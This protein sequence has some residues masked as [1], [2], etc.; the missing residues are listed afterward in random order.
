MQ[1]GVAPG[2]EAATVAAPVDA[3][4]AAGAPAGPGPQAQTGPAVVPD[5]GAPA[6]GGLG[7]IAG[8][9][10]ETAP[11]Q[12]GDG[13]AAS[14]GAGPG[15][16]AGT[17]P[18]RPG[19]GEGRGDGTPGRGGEGGQ[20]AVDKGQRRAEAEAAINGTLGRLGGQ[21]DRFAG[22]RGQVL[23]R[24]DAARKGAVEQLRSATGSEIA[25]VRQHVA[26]AAERLQVRAA[27][28][29]QA[30][31]ASWSASIGRL[32]TGAEG[33]RA[34]ILADSQAAL[35][36]LEAR[37]EAQVGQVRAHY[38]GLEGSL[39]S[40]AAGGAQQA[41][42]V[43]EGWYHRY[44]DGVP[45][46]KDNFWDGNLTY[47]R[48]QARGKAARAVSSSYADRIREVAPN[49]LG[50][51]RQQMPA[52]LAQIRQAATAARQ[53]ILSQ[54]QAAL[55]QLEQGVHAAMQAA[56]AQRQAQLEALA[57]GTHAALGQ[58]REAGAQRVEGLRHAGTEG[59]RMINE[60]ATTTR[61]QLDEAMHGVHGE[62]TAA[63]GML[64][65]RLQG[66]PP[67]DIDALSRRLATFEAEAASRLEGAGQRILEGVTGFE[68]AVGRGGTLGA[69]HL[70]KQ[71]AAAQQAF[72]SQTA[73]VQQRFAELEG[74]ARGGAEKFSTQGE[75]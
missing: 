54:R 74:R 52:D 69:D 41:K 28:A 13:G 1:G 40:L 49:L 72:Q 35:A 58:L 45:D 27:G 33:A 64:R 38:A 37:T 71:A 66:A 34:R 17:R 14:P 15:P 42:S 24:L 57:Q 46:K 20:Q 51:A 7:A 26:A 16:G 67:P 9:G 11:V 62:A 8:P 23:G 55:A 65:E 2:P 19:R 63:L 36:D 50:Q 48:A 6:G 47:R 4:A 73:A 5:A 53:H 12:L 61:S 21:L 56:Q 68:Q 59:V 60:R 25:S 32:R 30:I 22:Q 29:R 70:K 75:A 39:R 44:T 10:A 43:G 3:G 31:D 18:G